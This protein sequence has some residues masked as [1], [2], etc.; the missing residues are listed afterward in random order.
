MRWTWGLLDRRGDARASSPGAGATGAAGARRGRVGQLE[1]WKVSSPASA[2]AF[3]R[4]DVRLYQWLVEMRPEEEWSKAVLVAAEPWAE[5]L[6]AQEE[7]RAPVPGLVPL[8]G[9]GTWGGCS[10]TLRSSRPRRP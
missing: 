7:A 3:A 9:P 5:H 1:A 4:A 2:R 10:W 6:G 8:T